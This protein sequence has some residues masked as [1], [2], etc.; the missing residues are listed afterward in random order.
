MNFTDWTAKAVEIRILE[1]ADTLRISPATRGPKAYGNA[2]PEAVRRYDDAYGFHTARYRETAS[3]ASLGRMEQVWNWIN[4]LP[5]EVDRKLIYAWSWVKVRKGMKLSAFAA[6]NELT[7]R[8]LR[9]EISRIC[10]LIANNLNRSMQVRLN[11][12]DCGLSENQPD[13]A[14][15]T[16]TS[17]KCV[18]HWMAPDAKP[19]IDPAF[20]AKRV[21]DH[22]AIR[23][24]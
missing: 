20:A 10:Q 2:M 12:A 14:S 6:E 18:T 16:V 23:V 13:I 7:D 4:A 21:L 24:R 15:T 3:A 17:E 22:R 1:M 5:E 9:R 19:Q 11:N 8:T